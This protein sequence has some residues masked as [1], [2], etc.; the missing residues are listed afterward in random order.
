MSILGVLMF[1]ASM[2]VKHASGGSGHIGIMDFDGMAISAQER[3]VTLASN[4]TKWG[5][6]VYRLYKED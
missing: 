4:V 1:A 2:V 6:A 5:S 3:E